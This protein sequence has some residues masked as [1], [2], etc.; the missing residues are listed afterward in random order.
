MFLDPGCD[1]QDIDSPQVQ[2]DD[3]KISC[4]VDMASEAVVVLW[5]SVI[6]VLNIGVVGTHL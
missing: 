4:V 2:F 6:P 5:R 1:T 3:A